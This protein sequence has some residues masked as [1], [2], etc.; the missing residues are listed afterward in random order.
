MNRGGSGKDK[1]GGL[2]RAAML[3][4]SVF[5]V[6]YGAAALFAPRRMV[7]AGFAPDTGDLAEARLLLRAFG[8]HQLLVGALTLGAVWK[9]AL[10]RPASIL[11][12]AIDTF[13][14]GSAALEIRDRGGVDP[15]LLGG[16]GLSGAGI[17][18]FA[19]ALRSIDQRT[20]G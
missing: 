18:T 20:T 1:I 5:R 14:V 16:I 4:G 13:D 12:L 8:G 15:A 2:G 19:V 10:A 6:A 9:P 7:A 11:S 3:T 17:V